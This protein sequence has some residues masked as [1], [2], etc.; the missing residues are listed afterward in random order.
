MT[1]P[2][3]LQTLSA[4]VKGRHGYPRP[5]LQ[6]RPWWSL[7]GEW[8]FALDPEA[9]HTCPTQV[10]FTGAIRVPFAPETPASGVANTSFYRACWYQ[11]TFETPLLDEGRLLLHFGAVDYHASVWVN[12]R[13]AGRH[14]GGYTPFSFDITPLLLDEPEQTITVCAT[15]DPHDLA[16]PRGKQD[17]QLHPHSIWYPRTTGIWQTV[18][19]E[20]VP[21]AWLSHLRWTPHLTRW[22]I[23]LEARVEGLLDLGVKLHVRLQ[24][25]DQVIAD[26]TYAVISG[27]V[28]RRIALSDPGIDDY[29]NELLWSPAT[30][31][32]I[33]AELT[34]LDPDDEVV[35]RVR[36][37]TALRAI[38]VQG[39]RF[40]LNNR[41]YHLRLVLDQG[42]WPQTGLTAP[43]DA[44]LRRDVELAKAMGFNGVRCHQR[45]ADPRYLFWADLLGLMVWEEMPSA[46]RFTPSSVERVVTQWLDAMRRDMSHPCIVAWVPFNESWGVPD[47]P[48]SPAQ[49]HYVQALY[50]LTRTLD[51]SR[52]VIGND[53]WESVATDMIGIHDYDDQPHRIQ[54]RYGSHQVTSHLF[55]R[56]RP[57]GRLLSVGAHPYSGQPIVLSEFGGITLASDTDNTWGYSRANHGQELADRYAALMEVVRTLPLLAGFCYTQFADTYQEANGLLYAD[58]T[59]KFPL[60]DMAAAT[61]GP[62]VERERQLELSW[63][64]QLMDVVRVQYS[65]PIQE[66]DTSHAD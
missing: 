16:K 50:H 43:D 21:A 41:P 19:L 3:A 11:R 58:R 5:Q 27:D 47:L 56:E 48:D 1:S 9:R 39:D 51:P 22:E 61:C 62:Q 59:P 54:R 31:T 26:D 32:L 55:E 46:Y 66:H 44:A 52:P 12:G 25:G 34:L 2:Q 40:V 8:R 45:V 53:G 65:A 23:G 35:D 6:R 63:R 10:E 33:G 64:K 13:L 18:W 20:R 29:R 14:E 38:G 24:A 37:Y 36:S 28:H 42:Y 49:R 4:A 30:P 17:W 7:N 15:D 60:A 57:G